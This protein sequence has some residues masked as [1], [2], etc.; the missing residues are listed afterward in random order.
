[1]GNEIVRLTQNQM[2]ELFQ[3]TKQNISLHIKHIFEEGKLLE[4]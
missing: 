3:A 1:M 4:V 2:A